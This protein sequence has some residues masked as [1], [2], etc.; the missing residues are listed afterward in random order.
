MGLVMCWVSN[1]T[2]LATKVVFKRS[3]KALASLTTRHFITTQKPLV[4]NVLFF[5]REYGQEICLPSPNNWGVEWANAEWHRW[6]RSPFLVGALGICLV[7]IDSLCICLL[8]FVRA[9]LN[10]VIVSFKCMYIHTKVW[11]V[12]C[13]FGYWMMI[14]EDEYKVVLR[15][16]S[17]E[18]SSPL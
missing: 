2:S 14:D 4:A 12:F 17:C 10:L 13:G 16:I 3:S 18:H 7:I 15:S 5:S 9:L 1:L 8:T 11:E 6:T